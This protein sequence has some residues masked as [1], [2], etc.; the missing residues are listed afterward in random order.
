[1]AGSAR[2]ISRNESVRQ[3]SCNGSFD[4]PCSAEAAFPLFS[5]E[6]ERDWVTGW[7]PRPVFPKKIV[8]EPD[9]V[10]REG[11]GD[12]DAIWTIVDADWKGYRAEYVRVAPASHT[13]HIVVKL[14]PLEAERTKVTVSYTVT[15]FGANTGTVLEAF[16]EDAYAVRMHDWKRRIVAYLGREDS[17]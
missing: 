8:F 4:L 6:G 13:A 17:K 15:A 1:M 16:S 10:F 14:E 7:D 12:C 11:K 9:T 5:P 2:E 3:I